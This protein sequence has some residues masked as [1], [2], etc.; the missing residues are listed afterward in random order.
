M[1]FRRIEYIL[2]LAFLVLNAF[3][4]HAL[5][6]QKQ[7]QGLEDQR[8][9]QSRTIEAEMQAADVSAGNLS[10][11]EVSLPFMAGETENRL[12]EQANKLKHQDIRIGNN[13]RLF[14]HLD[15]PLDLPG[16]SDTTTADAFAQQALS[17]LNDFKNSDAMLYGKHYDFAF[18]NPQKKVIAFYQNGHE[19]RPIID[20]SGEIFFHLDDNYHVE[21]YEQSYVENTMPQGEDRQLISEKQAVENLYLYNE[22]P[23][24]AEVLSTALGYRTNLLL[25]NLFLYKPVW[26]VYIRNKDSETK[27]LY[28]DAINGT[29]IQTQNNAS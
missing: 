26:L 4:F 1:A 9:S 22:L 20:G 7:A 12:A 8:Q 5:F 29:I 27:I 15:K 10:E 6:E 19:G 11:E 16:L 21:S 14:S 25:D 24:H 3:L 18:Y 2:I 13:E 17:R 23:S 28:V